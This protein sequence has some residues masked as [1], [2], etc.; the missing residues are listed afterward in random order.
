MQKF[1]FPFAFIALFLWQTNSKHFT[2]EFQF[3]QNVDSFHRSL[4]KRS[5]KGDGEK[6]KNN[7]SEF[8]DWNQPNNDDIFMGIN[9][10]EVENCWREEEL[11]QI[12]MNE[13]QRHFL[14]KTMSDEDLKDSRR[15]LSKNVRI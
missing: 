12:C 4:R 13:W 7:A 1:L 14:T 8:G 2:E 3:Q 5:P 9:P 10:W 11:Y 6:S 15:N